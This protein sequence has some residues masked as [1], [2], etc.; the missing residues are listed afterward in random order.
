MHLPHIITPRVTREFFDWWQR[1]NLPQTDAVL[2][3]PALCWMACHKEGA[4]GRDQVRAV[5]GSRARAGEVA[6]RIARAIGAELLDYDAGAHRARAL[7]MPQ[8]EAR[9]L[10]REWTRFR[11]HRDQ[12]GLDCA[13]G[14][15]AWDQQRPIR[16]QAAC[17][18]S[19]IEKAMAERPEPLRECVTALNRTRVPE[20]LFHH[21][22]SL[23]DH[24]DFALIDAAVAGLKGGYLYAP[25]AGSLNWRVNLPGYSLQQLPTELRRL[26][27]PPELG[28]A[29]LDLSSAHLAIVAGLARSE[30]LIDALAKGDFWSRLAAETGFRRVDVKRCI[31]SMLYGASR[32]R[33]AVRLEPLICEAFDTPSANRDGWQRAVVGLFDELD[34]VG[35]HWAERRRIE[36]DLMQAM[37]I[38]TLWGTFHPVVEHPLYQEAVRARD[39]LIACAKSGMLFGAFLTRPSSNGTKPQT[40]LAA[41]CSS[42]EKALLHD[43]VTLQDGYRVVLEQH[44]GC[45][46]WVSAPTRLDEVV[47]RLR[48]RVSRTAKRLGIPTQLERKA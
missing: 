16:E 31:T 33:Q 23:V 44:D 6:Q 4:I 47:A 25:K 17:E 10:L 38:P 30:P 37:G 45:T 15:P 19:R 43:V 46:I 28:F 21:A 35:D 42:Y 32:F 41:V 18:R 2:L 39:S 8:D 22:E 12:L 1:F 7:V 27:M 9:E 29:E 26:L 36:F 13:T 3:Y 5:Y 48:R 11:V 24:D 14:R 34:R 40:T 20:V